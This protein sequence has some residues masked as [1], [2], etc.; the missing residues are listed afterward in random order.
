MELLTLKRDVKFCVFLQEWNASN[1]DNVVY[2]SKWENDPFNG[3]SIKISFDIYNV[4]VNTLKYLYVS[5][6]LKKCWQ[7]AYVSTKHD[8]SIKLCPAAKCSIRYK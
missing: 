8:M 7:G 3:N 6:Y 2:H 4:N 1:T 5:S